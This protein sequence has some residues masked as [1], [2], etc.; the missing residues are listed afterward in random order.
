MVSA[1]LSPSRAA[2]FMQCPLLYRFRVVDRLP[3]APSSAAAR[4]TLVHAVLERLFDLPADQRTYDAARA[5][6]SPQW[7]E[8]LAAEPELA[9][10][11]PEDDGA[12]LQ[13]W[14]DDAER[15]LTT[16]FGLEDRLDVA[17]DGRL[18]V[19]D[20]KTG[21]SPSELFETKALFQMRFYAL[22]LWKLRGVVPSMLQLVYLGNGEVVRYSPDE[23]ELAATERKVRALWS[24]IARAAETGDWRPSKS[25]L[26]DWCDFQELCPEWGGTPP[27]L[28]EHAAERAVDPAVSAA[29]TPAEE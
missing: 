4:G 10:L 27:P 7:D 12:G 2:D 29:V 18:R 22:V 3:Q 25:R 21:R 26:C 24:A 9:T 23:R 19:V 5:L 20:Y 28:P 17:V 6:L 11:F 1:A 14:L 16:W 8:L 13:H 15:L